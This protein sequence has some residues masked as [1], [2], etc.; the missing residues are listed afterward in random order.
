MKQKLLLGILLIFSIKSFS[1][2]S[3]FSLELNYP[4]TVGDNFIGKNYNGII[5]LGVKYRFANLEFLNIGASLNG[6]ILKNSKD[7]SFQPFDVTVFA[8]Q[9][10]I[11]AELD[12]ESLTK[13]HPSI[14]LGYTFMNFKTSGIDGFNFSNPDL[15]SSSQTENGIN[16]NLGLVYD[17]T[18]KLFVQVQY[19]LI[20]IGVEDGVPDTSYN[21]NIT[22][23]KFGFGL[24]I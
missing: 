1:Q 18:K 11:F 20:K 24:R 17:I 14:G 3:K 7:D 21:T 16:L 23:L 12:I 8:I 15:S 2:D 19:D 6:G 9:P 22:I 4:L 10:S 5:D 13:F